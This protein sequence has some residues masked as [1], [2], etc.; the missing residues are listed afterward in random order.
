MNRDRVMLVTGASGSIGQVIARGAAAD[1]WSVIAHG[2]TMASAERAAAML[3]AHVPEAR[4]APAA[5]DFIEEGAIAA[6]IDRIAAD[7]GRLDGI[8]NCA[9]SA[10]PGVVGAFARTDPSAYTAFCHHAL[11]TLQWLC[12]AAF[13]LMAKGGGGSLV[14]LSSDAGRFAAPNQSLIATTRA[15]IMAFVR[16]IALEASRDR[17][18]VNCVSAT[19]VES[20]SIVDKLEAAGNTRIEAARKRAG[21]GLP[22]AEDIANIALFLLGPGSTRLTG[23]VISVNGGLNS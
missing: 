12:F 9:V 3:R 1:G 2:R 23:Q 4:V 18:R 20:T 14:A 5:C 19:Y 17:I 22:H 11:T 21:L 10:P 13:P 15:G 7:H 6:L 8:A 16:N